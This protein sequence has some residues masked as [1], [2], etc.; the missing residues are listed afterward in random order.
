MR[1][2]AEGGAFSQQPVLG[3]AE[4]IVAADDDVIEQRD[5]QQAAGPL[6][7]PGDLAII[8]AGRGIARGMVVNRHDGR[9][10]Q[11]KGSSN[12]FPRKHGSAV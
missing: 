6:Q 12:N 10:I 2:S 8:R 7:L 1:V 5:I 9:G 11:L 3:E 4:A